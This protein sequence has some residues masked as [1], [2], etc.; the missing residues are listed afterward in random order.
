MT[1]GSPSQGALVVTLANLLENSPNVRCCERCRTSPN[2][3]ASQNAVVP[4]LPSRTWYP[5]GRENSWDSPSRTR[6]TRD[7]TGFW[8][9]EVPM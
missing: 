5:S 2:A 3:A 4:P 9:C 7:F 1:V 6:P 8:R